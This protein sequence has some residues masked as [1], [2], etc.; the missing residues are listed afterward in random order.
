MYTDSPFPAEMQSMNLGVL[1]SLW[2]DLGV[3][4][5][6]RI[7]CPFIMFEVHL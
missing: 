6:M 4:L 5:P 2:E 7:R 1:D 3:V